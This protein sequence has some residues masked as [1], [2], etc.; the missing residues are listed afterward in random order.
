MYQMN[1]YAPSAPETSDAPER[2]AERAESAPETETRESAP[3]SNAPESAPETPNTGAL[4]F[5][6]Q[7]DAERE[8]ERK[9]VRVYRDMSA[10]ATRED[11]KLVCVQ[12]ELF[13][14]ESLGALQ[15]ATITIARDKRE[16]VLRVELESLQESVD[17][18]AKLGIHVIRDRRA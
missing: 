16:N 11:G 7:I 14:D 12:R 13:A 4:D 1:G 5:S 6:A 8:T 10:R 17:A 18:L 9:R 15:L 3:E 2:D